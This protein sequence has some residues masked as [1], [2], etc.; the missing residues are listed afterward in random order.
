MRNY[1]NQSTSIRDLISICVPTYNGEKYLSQCVRSI[2][3]QTYENVEI[4]VVDDGSSDNTL[5][6]INRLANEDG[7]IRVIQNDKNLGLV[8]NWNKCIREAKGAWIKFLFQDDLMDSDCCSSMIEF[9]TKN[10]VSVVLSDRHYFVNDVSKEAKGHYSSIK[11]LSHYI[12][13]SKVITTDEVSKIYA[14][15]F[16][17]VNFLGEP[18][19]GLVKKEVFDRYGF[20]DEGLK[21][22]VDFEFWFRIGTNEPIGYINEPLNYFRVHGESESFRNAQNSKVNI[23]WIDRIH[24]GLMIKHGRHYQKFRGYLQ[25]HGVSADTL[26]E[27]KYT[28]YIREMG[29]FRSRQHL[30]RKAFRYFNHSIKNFTKAI[31]SDLNG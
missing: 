26:L 5:A 13:E 4:L 29:Y 27:D 24:L 3:E 28:H 2:R 22:L 30:D 14:D 19:V 1:S 23:S 25:D 6:L 12:S 20:F 17:G 21:Q 8:P 10:K 16:L 18:I 9:A 7:R 11:R 15:D 31:R